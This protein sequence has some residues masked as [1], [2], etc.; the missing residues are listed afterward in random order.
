MYTHTQVHHGIIPLLLLD[1]GWGYS[2]GGE[3]GAELTSQF[4][5]LGP[6]YRVANLID[7]C[8]TRRVGV[9]A[10]ASSLASNGTI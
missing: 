2:T 6:S 10:Q 5:T 7:S 3:V 8:S 4:I 9:M 1:G